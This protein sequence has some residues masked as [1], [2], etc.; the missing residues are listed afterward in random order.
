[1]MPDFLMNIPSRLPYGDYHKNKNGC[2]VDLEVRVLTISCVAVYH[3]R[4]ITTNGLLPKKPV[5]FE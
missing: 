2:M 5:C 3:Y 1:M 4:R